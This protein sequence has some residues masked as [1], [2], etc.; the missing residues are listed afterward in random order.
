MIHMAITAPDDPA[1]QRFRA[2]VAAMYG[3]RVS[4]L[5]LFGS[6]ARGDAG[7]DS[8]YDVAVF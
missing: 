4:R 2:A 7:P 6:R 3:D 8:V 1:L 5:V